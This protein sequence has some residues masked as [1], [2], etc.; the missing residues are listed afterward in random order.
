MK[1]PSHRLTLKR[2]VLRTLGGAELGEVVGGETDGT[3]TIITQ[4]RL[5]DH[6]QDK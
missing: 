6:Q 5:N 2:D 3:V 1:K 4:A